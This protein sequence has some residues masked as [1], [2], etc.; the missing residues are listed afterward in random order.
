MSHLDENFTAFQAVLPT[1]DATFSAD[2]I[3]L[4]S[5]GAS[6]NAL[7]AL[8]TDGMGGGRL[9]ALIT[10]EGL[11]PDTAHIQHIHGVFD[12]MG[13]PANSQSPTIA[14]DADGDGYVEVL[15]GVPSYGDVLLSLPGPD[16]MPMTDAEGN[17][18][19]YAS[20]DIADMS[21]FVSPV[22]GAQYSFEDIADLALREYVLHGVTV[23][24][25][26][27]AGTDG[28]VN[29]T[30][31][32]IPI[33]PAG[34]SEL[35]EVTPEMAAMQ[36][37]R[38][39][40]DAGLEYR[41]DGMDNTLFAGA[42][43]DT[44]IAGAGDDTIYG[45][46]GSD[47]LSGMADNDE[48][49]GG[50]GDDLLNGGSG[51][52]MLFGGIGNDELLGGLGNDMAYGGQGDDTLAGN[53][54][55]DTLEGGAG[56]DFIVGGRGEDE[57]FGGTGNDRL[58][59]GADND[60]AYGGQGDDTVIGH[61]GDDYLEGGEGDDQIV[62]GTG[63]DTALG[64]EGDDHIIGGAGNDDLFGGDGD[65]LLGGGNG[66]DLLVGGAGDDILFGGNGDDILGGGSGNNR[67]TGGAGADEFHFNAGN[68]LDF[69]RD[70]TQGEDVISF[71]DGGAISFANSTN[72]DVRGANDLSE[73][74][75]DTVM[76]IAGLDMMN[77]QQ[78]RLFRG[79]CG[80]FGFRS[81]A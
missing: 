73:M 1:A 44:V 10:A 15:E 80:W 2:I 67:L 57:L 23:P 7:F 30:G 3:A 27:G 43:M 24:D 51:D 39:A 71:L 26:A 69:V 77:D 56:D 54:G 20:Y 33:L 22:T 11:T 76:N 52:D 14:A 58:L 40:L 31:G 18:N 35:T 66:D 19:F 4:N 36:F 61:G 41:L 72:S 5:S 38:Q 62:G 34:A 21:N 79:L 37:D 75:F 64:G 78:V 60:M 25:G 29:G 46:D 32:F 28:E 55:D 74:D 50:E 13:N 16:G 53:A 8:E 42:G 45:Q 70:F 59:G 48:L 68:G 9:H 63:N 65:D 47:V 81:F 12:E 49:Y 6:G 17:L